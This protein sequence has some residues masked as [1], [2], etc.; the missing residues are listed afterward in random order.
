MIDTL[1]LASTSMIHSEALCITV[2]TQLQLLKCAHIIINRIITNPHWYLY[3]QLY[4]FERTYCG[5]LHFRRR[6]DTDMHNMVIV[7][8]LSNT[9]GK[10]EKDRRVN[11]TECLEQMRPMKMRDNDQ[12]TP[13]IRR[14]STGFRVKYNVS[15]NDNSL[16]ML[17]LSTH[18]QSANTDDEN[19]YIFN[20]DVEQALSGSSRSEGQKYYGNYQMSSTP[21]LCLLPPPLSARVAKSGHRNRIGSD[22]LT[23]ILDESLRVSISISSFSST[24]SQSTEV[25][26]ITGEMKSDHSSSSVILSG[27]V[28]DLFADESGVADRPMAP[29]RQKS[30]TLKSVTLKS[31]SRMSVRMDDFDQSWK[32]RRTHRKTSCSSSS[33]TTTL[34][35]SCDDSVSVK[36]GNDESDSAYDYRHCRN[37]SKISKELLYTTSGPSSWIGNV[38]CQNRFV[39]MLLILA[40]IAGLVSIPLF[41]EKHEQELYHQQTDQA[42]RRNVKNKEHIAPRRL[43]Y[44]VVQE[45]FENP[46]IDAFEDQDP[47]DDHMRSTNSGIAV[48]DFEN[49][50]TG[51]PKDQNRVN[52]VRSINAGNAVQENF[53]NSMIDFF[54]AQN[55]VGEDLKSINSGIAVQEHFENSLMDAFEAQSSVDDHVRNTNSGIAVQEHFKHSMRDAFEAQNSVDNHV[56]STNFGIVVREHFLKSMMDVFENQNSEQSEKNKVTIHSVQAKTVAGATPVNDNLRKARNISILQTLLDV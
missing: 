41:L 51:A 17:D 8:F 46:M 34:L 54:E 26:P 53:E 43:N 5:T 29:V 12:V 13:N 6:Q 40:S 56:R 28:N 55:S 24:S 39:K 14:Q 49:T 47:I 38:L 15:A 30:H 25:N 35:T 10:R 22:R 32:R 2:K 19:D 3:L 37:D 50:M 23:E 9:K 4:N 7:H 42:R 18:S 45:H 27:S 36:D 48:Q 16:S 11:S 31:M 44:N 1:L 52:Y 33:T 20:S 21:S